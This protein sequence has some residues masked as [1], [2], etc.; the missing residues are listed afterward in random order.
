MRSIVLMFAV[1]VLCGSAFAQSKSI[2]SALS[3]KACKTLEANPDEGG[4][5]IGECPGT[6]GFKLRVIEGDLRQTVDIVTPAKKIHPLEFW[7]FFQG[8][9][10]VGDK[11]EWLVRSGVPR[12]VIVR[13]N[14]AENPE[15]SERSRSY[16]IVAK[17]GKT[18]SCIT[19]IIKPA[20]DQN[21]LAR[22]AAE[23]AP[24]AP[25]KTGN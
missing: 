12:A 23:K 3:E 18:S 4:S 11:A 10:S 22:K 7:N 16:L 24:T 13:F 6:G 20:R 25:C 19:D 1:F 8:F 14:V 15:H 2:Y 17:V 5:Y 9:S 21:V